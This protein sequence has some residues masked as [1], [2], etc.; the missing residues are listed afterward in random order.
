MADGSHL[1]IYGIGGCFGEWSTDSKILL[2]LVA[3]SAGQ[4]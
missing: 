4:K 1:D 2:K 3:H